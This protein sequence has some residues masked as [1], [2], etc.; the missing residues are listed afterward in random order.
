M[1]MTI[2]MEI[3]MLM[4]QQE[5]EAPAGPPSTDPYK[6]PIASCSPV[7]IIVDYARGGACKQVLRGGWGWLQSLR[8]GPI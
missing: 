6:A 5:E 8:E 1:N 2:I 7:S 4:L 3:I